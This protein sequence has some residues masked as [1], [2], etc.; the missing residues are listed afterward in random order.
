MPKKVGKGKGKKVKVEEEQPVIVKKEE[1]KVKYI[2]PP[3]F[4]AVKSKEMHENM[5]KA[6]ETFFEEKKNQD[7]GHDGGDDENNEENESETIHKEK[8]SQFNPNPELTS[9]FKQFKNTFFPKFETALKQIETIRDDDEKNGAV[10]K[11]YYWYI[12]T[13]ESFKKLHPIEITTHKP[14]YD[15]S[16]DISQRLTNK[17]KVWEAQMFPREF[18]A[19]NRTQDDLSYLP[20]RE[21]YIILLTL[22]NYN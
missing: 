12:E 5:K 14:E 13:V 21:R 7:D 15:H 22:T 9:D 8:F 2:P 11:L 20:P 16:P 6:L 10:Q 17:S 18:E 4:D 19:S 3:R 1:P